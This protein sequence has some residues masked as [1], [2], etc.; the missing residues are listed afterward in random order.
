M[1]NAVLMVIRALA[2]IALVFAGGVIATAG[3]CN[4]SG[5]LVSATGVIALAAPSIIESDS[6]SMISRNRSRQETDNSWSETT[7]E[8]ITKDEIQCMKCGYN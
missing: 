4:R 8:T 1:N 5:C 7:W 6:V 3:Q 2:C